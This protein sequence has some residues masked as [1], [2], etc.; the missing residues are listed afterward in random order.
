MRK[1]LGL[2]LWLPSSEEAYTPRISGGWVGWEAAASRGPRG[3]R[4][5]A[6]CRRRRGPG[7]ALLC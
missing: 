3:I 1:I 2:V 4:T 7:A 6:G 5:H